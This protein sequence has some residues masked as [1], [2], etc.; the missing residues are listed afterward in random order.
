MAA[1][2]WAFN[3]RRS[4]VYARNG[5]VATSQPLAVEAGLQVL[6]A[7]GNAADAAVAVAAALNVTEPTSTGIGGDCFCLFFD[8]K[9]KKVRALNG[10]GRAPAALTIEHLRAKGY[11]GNEL[12]KFDVNTVTVPGAAAG[13]VDTVENFGSGSLSMQDI[14]QPAINL[15][16]QGYPVA[17]V[18]AQNWAKQVHLLRSQSPYGGCF[19]VDGTRA[20]REGEVMRNPELAET[21]RLLASQRKKGFYEG[22]VAQAIVSVLQQKGGV[23]ALSDLAQHTS[24]IVEPIS[25]DY[26]GVT[27]WECPPNGQGLVALVALNI[28]QH[29]DLA[30]HKHTS[31]EYLHILIEALRLAFA[32]AQAH[33]A[34]PE[35]VAVPVARLLSTEYGAERARL[36]DARRATRE[37]STGVPYAS[38]DTVYL[39]V[40]DQWGN[41][42][43]FINSNYM[44]FGSCIVP[45]GCGFTLQN[46]G[47]NFTLDSGHPN[48]L[49]PGKRPYHTIIPAMVTRDG[50]LWLSY[51]VMGGFMQPQGHVQ[52]LA[53]M[54]HYQM[55]PQQ[56][57]D[58]PRFCLP[59]GTHGLRVLVEDGVDKDT[60][61]ALRDMGHEVLVVTDLVGGSFDPFSAHPHIDRGYFGRG[62]VIE[63]RAGVLCAGSDP[64]ADGLAMGW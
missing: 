45:E 59:D 31:A 53:S 61:Q 3:S 48:H 1:S 28:L 22:R 43:S 27:V 47:H 62:Q 14:L 21:F 51:G 49:A 2:S 17:P 30:S 58:T 42:C 16:E 56:A 35:H 60:V 36:I 11:T 50:E 8:A 4:N 39:T 5:M 7:G 54:L 10:S 46:R 20:P 18:T 9:T 40:A 37:L 29:T 32:D 64:R 55:G 26:H 25:L 63:N 41:A 57:L 6:R 13:W 23:M 52:V 24:S 12:P 33:L 19:L 34:D 15:A 38:S 44:G